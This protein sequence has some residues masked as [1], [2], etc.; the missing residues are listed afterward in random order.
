MAD[1]EQEGLDKPLALSKE[2]QN[3]LG[4]EEMSRLQVTKEIWNY[5]DEHDLQDSEDKRK[6]VADDKLRDVF[7]KDEVTMFEMPGLLSEHLTDPDD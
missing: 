4:V 2:L 5:I 6:I 7:G 3:V 1:N